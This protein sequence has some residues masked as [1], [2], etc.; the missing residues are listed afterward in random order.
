[1]AL[2]SLPLVSGIPGR[3]SCRENPASRAKARAR[4]DLPLLP[5]EK[6]TTA[7]MLSVSHSSGTPPSQRIV[8]SQ[9]AMSSSVVRV[10]A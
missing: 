9:Q 3:H 1:M 6:V 2:S 7:D 5:P 10:L 4:S 8:S